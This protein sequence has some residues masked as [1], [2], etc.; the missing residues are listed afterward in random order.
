MRKLTEHDIANIIGLNIN[1]YTVEKARVKRGAFSDSDCYGI[2]LAVS[3][4]GRYVTWQF[5]FADGWVP[6]AYWGH[7]FMEDREAV[8]RDF[9]TRGLGRLAAESEGVE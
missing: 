3:G 2:I 9:D 6:E 7:Y 5:H 1:G 8:L 4:S